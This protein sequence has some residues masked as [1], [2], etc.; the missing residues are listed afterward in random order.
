MALSHHPL[1]AHPLWG[2][3]G[4]VSLSW[5][6]GLCVGLLALFDQDKP[7]TCGWQVLC[8]PVNLGMGNFR[9]VCPWGGQ[10][11]VLSPFCGEY[12]IGACSCRD[13]VTQTTVQARASVGKS[14]VPP[15]QCGCG[16]CRDAAEPGGF[17]SHYSLTSKRT[18][19]FCP[20]LNL[21][22]LNTYLCVA[23]FCTETTLVCFYSPGSSQRLMDDVAGSQWHLFACADPSQSL[24]V[25]S[26]CPQ[27]EPGRGAH[28]LSTENSPFWPSHCPQ[29]FYQTLDSCSGP[30][31][32][33]GMSHVS[34]HQHLPC[35]GSCQP[36][37]PHSQPQSALS[38]HAWVY[39]KPPEVIPHPFPGD[40]PSRSFDKHSQGGG[41]TLA[42]T[43][44]IVHAAQ[45]LLG[46]TQVLAQYFRQVL[47]RPAMPDSP[48]HVS[49]RP[50][51]ILLRDHFNIRV[52][53]PSK[54]IPCCLQWSGQLWHFGL[55]GN[56]CPRESLFNLPHPLMSS[57]RKHPLMD[58]MGAS[59][60]SFIGPGSVVKRSIVSPYH[61]S[62][63]GDGFPHLEE[64][65]EVAVCHAHLVTFKRFQRWLCAMHI[66]VQ[67][68]SNAV[69]HYLNSAWGTRS[70]SL[71]MKVRAIIQWCLRSRISLV[72]VHMLGPDKR[73]GGSPLSSSSR[74]HPTD[75]SLDPRV[76]SPLFDIWGLPTVDLF[77]TWL[78]SKVNAF[79]S[80]LPDPL[81]LTGSSLQADWSNGLL[82]M[83]PTPTPPVPCCSQGD[84]GGGS[85]HCDF[86]MVASKRM[87]SPGPAGLAAP[88]GPASVVARVRWS[89]PQS[90]QA[91]VAWPLGTLPSRL[92]SLRR[93][94]HRR[95]IFLTLL[96]PYMHS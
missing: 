47:W 29:S 91:G 83:Y 86:T 92:R 15:S 17:Y 75:W 65:P 58:W 11:R 87:V 90:R 67:M 51:W 28:C 19:G 22:R 45:G 16:D 62:R 70:W 40:A 66:L 18:G 78:N 38:F 23:K 61:L 50:L 7:L 42:Q 82:Y 39:H 25:F 44:M 79:Y 63:A 77:A 5:C 89:S 6:S 43:D 12:A 33:A 52:D 34:L 2:R 74:E 53:H 68:D 60:R 48:A 69:M 26:G 96:P 1:L 59:L 95:G 3:G 8:F 84:S 41:H 30:F 46:L 73:Q 32:S 13:S 54:L 80:C 27:Q 85:G 64:I 88:H 21:S 9:P 10:T 36:G 49:L 94:P 20:S 14:L 81:A 76:T 72:A 56:W 37:G 71:D 4:W 57:Q 31:A 93:S 35:S 24:A 55:V